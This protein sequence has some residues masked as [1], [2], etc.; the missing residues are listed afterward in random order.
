M[1]SRVYKKQIKGSI[2][3]RGLLYRSL[4]VFECV[5][6][7]VMEFKR[8]CVCKAL[9]MCVILGDRVCPGLCM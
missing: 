6:L 3:A 5:R 4:C 8:E 9:R 7:C 1:Q 2:S